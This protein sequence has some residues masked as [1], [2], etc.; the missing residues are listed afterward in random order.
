MYRKVWLSLLLVVLSA[1]QTISKQDDSLYLDL[2]GKVGISKI[3]DIFIYEIGET[4]EVVHHFEDTDLDRFREKQIEHLC[5]LSGG[6]CVYTGDEMLP[7]H[8]GM[9]I[10]ESEFNAITNAMIR[11]LD[12]AGISIAIRNRLLAIIAA[13]RADVIYQ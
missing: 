3:I 11:A 7:V 5:L 4:E 13:M 10:S 2:G 6:P 9:N 12:T 8:Q 1:C